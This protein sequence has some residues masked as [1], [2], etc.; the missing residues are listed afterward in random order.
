MKGAVAAGHPLTAE[1][2]ARVLADGGTAVDACLAAAFVSWVVESPLTGPAAGGFLLVHR[3]K[4]GRSRLL[5]FFVAVPGKGLARGGGGEM[6]T[7][8]VDFDGSTTQAFRVGAASVAVPGS[9]AG[10]AKAHELHGTVPWA[11]LFE[12]AVD[13]A[14]NGV[15]LTPQQAYLHAILDVILSHTES[16][17]AVYSP[18]GERLVAG[19]VLVMPELARTL[20]LLADQGPTPLYGGELGRALSEYI[21]SEGGSLTTQ[22]LRE[23][24]V[25]W[26][27]PIQARFLRSTFISIPPPSS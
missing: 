3:A 27:R 12:P 1:A 8:D 18:R 5:D 11:R 6:E 24:R 10:L 9:V 16:G 25:I 2:A 13:L 15:E 19:D 4:D 23:Y 21:Q 20:E 26:R 22:D 14:R 7:I 17:R